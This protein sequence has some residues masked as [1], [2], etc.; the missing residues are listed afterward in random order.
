MSIRQNKNKQV[1]VT[2]PYEVFVL[3]QWYMHEHQIKDRN[4]AFQQLII[5]GLENKWTPFK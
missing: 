4:E 2:I 1:V 3:V 5:S